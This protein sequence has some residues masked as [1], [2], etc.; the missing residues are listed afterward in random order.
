LINITIFF[1]VLEV[2]K[3]N[4]KVLRDLVFGERLALQ[5]CKWSLLAMSSLGGRN[6]STSSCLFYKGT[7]PM[8]EGSSVRI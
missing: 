3:F 5:V 6:K 8:H 7:N 4:I 2:G 1:I